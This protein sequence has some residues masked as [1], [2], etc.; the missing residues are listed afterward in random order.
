M[1]SLT[2]S[3]SQLMVVTCRER[4]IKQRESSTK[5]VLIRVWTWLGCRTLPMACLAGSGHSKEA[6]SL[7]LIFL[8]GVNK[9]KPAR[10]C[11]RRKKWKSKTG[12]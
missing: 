12:V 11:I 9:L 5:E 10:P 7:P 1:S 4:F 3:L 8:E 2:K 6:N